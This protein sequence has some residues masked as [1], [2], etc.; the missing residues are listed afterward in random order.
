MDKIILIGCPG[1]GKS[2]LSFKLEDI[3]KVP[4]LHLDKIYH[5][6]NNTRI[7]R[8]ELKQKVDDF[9]R[10]N[11]EWIIDGNYI[12]T[13]DQRI[14]L[15]DTIIFLDFSTQTCVKNVIE[16][17]KKEKTKDMAEGFDNSKLNP[18]FL[19][20]VS[21]FNLETRP[22]VYEKLKAFPDKKVII[23]KNYKEVDKFIEKVRKGH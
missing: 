17:S 5:I 4:V 22:L 7:T 11:S 21:K 12:S 15:C 16:R 23:L 13:L 9:A 8:E 1:S 14:A 2:T 18:E 6:D 19:E 10:S 20:F 3:L